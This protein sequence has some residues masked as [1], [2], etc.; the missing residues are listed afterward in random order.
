MLSGNIFFSV[1]VKTGIVVSVAL[2]IF[3]FIC[4]RLF[5]MHGQEPHTVKNLDSDHTSRL[6]S[7]LYAHVKVLSEYI[8]E[9]HHESPE[10][11][12]ETIKYIASEMQSTGYEPVYHKFGDRDYSNIISE[13]SG[14]DK[15][16]E[17]IIIGAH[18]DTVWLSPG[19]DDNASGIAAL[20]EIAK[21]LFNEN[22]S[23]SVRFVAFANEE[24]PFSES[25][26]MGSRVYA[27]LSA[28]N[29]ENIIAMFSLEMLGFYSDKQGSQ[30]YPPVIRP[31]YPDTGNFIAFVS[32]LNSRSLLKKAVYHYYDANFSAQ[33]LA[34]PEF[35]VPDIRRSDHAS[36]WDSGY[37][38]VMITDTA[39]FRN[40]NYHSVGDRIETLDFERMASVVSGLTGMIRK[41][42]NT[43]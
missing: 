15:P 11:I 38:A 7:N 3:M 28:Q 25:E 13:I 4:Y 40:P 20:L 19:A 16:D 39:N 23:R 36:F 34:A 35:L 22:F 41:L 17:I 24:Q 12:N 10:A 26:S 42:A 33:G 43:N 30:N 6:A 18:Y 1:L 2:L 14:T 27:K 31:F 29:R 37:Q 9:R 21:N 32:N 5:V 8:G